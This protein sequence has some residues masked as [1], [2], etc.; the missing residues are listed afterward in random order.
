M[1]APITER[2]RKPKIRFSKPIHFLALHLVGDLGNTWY[3]IYPVNLKVSLF[4]EF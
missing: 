3:K 2:L 1:W 4:F